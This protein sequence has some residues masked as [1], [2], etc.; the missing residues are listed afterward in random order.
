MVLDVSKSWSIVQ[1]SACQRDDCPEAYAADEL[2]AVIGRM[3][4]AAPLRSD[5][6]P[7]T[8]FFVLDAG[9]SPRSPGGRRRG[10]RF[11][12]RAAE[13]RVE[14][15]GEDGPALV[16]S[17]YDFMRALGVRWVAPGA[18]GERLLRA[19][20][21]E[22]ART[23]G[24]S[25]ENPAAAVLVLGHSAYL[26]RWEEELAW[27][28]RAGYSS[29]I[30]RL[31]RDPLA[32][33]AA[34]YD[35]Y[36]S[37]KQELSAFALRAGLDIELAGNLPWESLAE[38]HPE[39]RVFHFWPEE[40]P[41]GGWR[42]SGPR[43]APPPLAERLSVACKLAEKLSR[44]RPDAAASI[45]I[46]P[47][48]DALEDAIGA[49]GCEQI[50][51]LELLWAP[52]SRTWARALGD[53]ESRINAAALESFAGAASF[54]KK[55]GGGRIA[56][57]ERWEDGLLFTGAVPPLSAVLSADI[58]AYRA[59]GAE[60]VGVLRAGCR[61][62]EA[63]RPNAYLVPVLTAQP[64]STE[65]GAVIADWAAASYGAAASAMLDYWRGIEKAWAVGLD[66]EEGET[67][68]RDS[69]F[70]LDLARR[71]PA[72]WGDPW[73]ADAARLA[74][75]R[76]RCEELFDHLRAAEKALE[77][78]RE[79]TADNGEASAAVCAERNEY[80][81]SGTLLELMCARL[82]AYHELTAGDERA[83]ADIA[84]LALSI[85]GALKTKLK[86]CP[87]KKNRA[88]SIFLVRSFYDL[89][90]R[91]LRRA[92]ARS[93]LRRMIDAWAQAAIIALSAARIRRVKA[94]FFPR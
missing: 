16:Q 90:L 17:V 83:A 35:Y 24:A 2:A 30:V 15:W 81:V 69:G 92:S 46:K 53:A 21:L 18:R 11:S 78:A 25:S 64:P 36:L 61:R 72:D 79:T 23:S 57:V 49:S 42:S 13:D 67:G 28:A 71:A 73:K 9:A 68:I 39:A 19:R 70:G 85:S 6:L 47:G 86:R 66:I 3:T 22:L 75:R 91:S 56:V 51:N 65:A 14:I 52:R 38:N 48:D 37:I 88:E 84:N 32:L 4:G 44:V 7:Q 41:G 74:S 45:L 76:A 31:T 5:S 80:A 43:S 62:S 34:P 87:D 58:A 63:P 60:A 29:V 50:S 94:G 12:W 10:A 82:S 93:G 89:G 27:A 55:A 59:A 26:E 33:E 54:W 77:K 1:R 8:R 40:L 20:R